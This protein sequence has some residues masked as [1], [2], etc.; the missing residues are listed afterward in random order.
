MQSF[1]KNLKRIRE[2]SG[3]TQEQLAESINVTRQAVS[4]WERGRTEPDIATIIALSKVLNVDAEEL[5]FGSKTKRY[6]RFQKKYLV[7]AITSLSLV[8]IVLLLRLTLD[9]HLETQ[10]NMSY[11]G[12]EVHFF[13]FRLLI[14]YLGNVSL[15]VFA[16]S[17][18]ALFYKVCLWGWWRR[19]AFFLGLAAALPSLLVIADS[20]LAMTMPT[21]KA[22]FTYA[23]F[24]STIPSQPIQMLL[25][26]LLPILSGVLLFLS[27]D[28]ASDSSRVLLDD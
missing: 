11:I 24:V 27:F 20:L 9:S 25:F 1:A 23:I 15:G 19:G 8:L 14:P 18:V 26:D 5:I 7:C 3:M 12:K 2:E 10:I 4:C 13:I 28:N 22:P 21:Y 6:D 16:V 17:L